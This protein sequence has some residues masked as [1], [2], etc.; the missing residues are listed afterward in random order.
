MQSKHKELL[1]EFLLCINEKRYYDAH[2]ALEKIWYPRRYEDD[3]EIKLLKGF[4]NASVCF[5][6]LQRGRENP[7]KKAWNTYLKYRPLLYKVRSPF[8][9]KYHYLARTVEK[10]KNTRTV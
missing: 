10:L 5:E 9:N 2:E 1:D 6:L 7:S 4:I 3:D 8:L